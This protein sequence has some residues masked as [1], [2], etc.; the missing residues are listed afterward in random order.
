MLANGRIWNCY[1]FLQ[2]CLRVSF[3]CEHFMI[4]DKDICCLCDILLVNLGRNISGRFKIHFTLFAFYIKIDKLH[5]KKLALNI[6]N[7]KAKA[8]RCIFSYNLSEFIKI[9]KP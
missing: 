9:S 7:S 2:L 4:K 6:A 5:R 8:M 1:R 3:T